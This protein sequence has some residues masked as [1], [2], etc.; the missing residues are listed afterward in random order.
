MD[1]AR[2][3][4]SPSSSLSE[5]TFFLN[6]A[7][8]G[9]LPSAGSS[10]VFVAF[11]RRLDRAGKYR[12]LHPGHVW[13]I[14]MALEHVVQS[15]PLSDHRREPNLAQGIHV[16][17]TSLGYRISVSHSRNNI[18]SIKHCS[19]SMEDGSLTLAGVRAL[20]RLIGRLAPQP[21]PYTIVPGRAGVFHILFDAPER[22]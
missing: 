13:E 21:N 3:P 6:P 9:S 10:M 18:A 14:A 11:W 7:G 1:L 4:Q 16:A 17:Q 8:I 12:L 22:Q 15:A 2:D 20:A 5:S 19:V